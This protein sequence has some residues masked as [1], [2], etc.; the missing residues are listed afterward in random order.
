MAPPPSVKAPA[1]M[2]YPKDYLTDEH[3]VVMTLEEEG[4]YRRL[5]D[6]CWLQGSIPDDMQALARMCKNISPRRMEK[7]WKSIEPCFR[8][9]AGRWYHPRLDIERRGQEARREAKSRAGKLGAE[10]KHGKAKAGTATIVPVAKASSTIAPASALAEKTETSP[11]GDE[12]QGPSFGEIMGVVR[13]ELHL[14]VSDEECRRSGHILKRDYAGKIDGHEIIDACRGARKLIDEGSVNGLAPRQ[15][16]GLRVLRKW[17]AE[18]GRLLFHAA[19]DFERYGGADSER[20]S[21]ESG[22]RKIKLETGE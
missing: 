6:H 10:A 8:K 22:L 18:N 13:A 12:G 20:R 5:L 14:G 15:P 16:V 19:V 11:N 2:W 17:H 21:G 3:T 7:L 1:F 4:A 9:R